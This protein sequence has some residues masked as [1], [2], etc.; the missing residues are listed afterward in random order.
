MTGVYCILVSS[1]PDAKE[2]AQN[3]VS[4]PAGPVLC[5]TVPALLALLP[6]VKAHDP[7]LIYR[8]CELREVEGTARAN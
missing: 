5:Y 4:T 1:G 3:I 6:I 2:D 8:V 7:D